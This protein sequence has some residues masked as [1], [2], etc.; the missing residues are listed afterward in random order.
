MAPVRDGPYR[1]LRHPNYLAVILELVSIP[2]I[3]GAWRTATAASVVNAVA[4][5]IRIPAEN[6][7]LR[8][9]PARATELDRRG[10]TDVV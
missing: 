2:M 10:A 3:F 8:E 7:A 9:A 5:A 4:L 6:R 1:W